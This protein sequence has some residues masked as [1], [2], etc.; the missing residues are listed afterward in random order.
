MKLTDIRFFCTKCIWHIEAKEEEDFVNDGYRYLLCKECGSIV[1]HYKYGYKGNIPKVIIID[2]PIN[3]T[4]GQIDRPGDK[5]I[6]DSY[7]K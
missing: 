1:G 5:E 6:L 3:G 7:D 4:I 2:D